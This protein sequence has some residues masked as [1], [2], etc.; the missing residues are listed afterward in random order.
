M[1]RK[2]LDSSSINFIN[3]TIKKIF[4]TK[5]TIINN[6]KNLEKK[7]REL[8]EIQE[9]IKFITDKP[10]RGLCTLVNE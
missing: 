8:I 1:K 5:Q 7:E 2:G 6:I 3:K 4:N 9:I 10:K